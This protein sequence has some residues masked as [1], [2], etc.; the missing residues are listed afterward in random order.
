MLFQKFQSSTLASNFIKHILLNTSLPILQKISDNDLLIKGNLYIYDKFVIEAVE[1]GVFKSV[2]TA[3]LY[4]SDILYPSP[5]LILNVGYKL[6]RYRV[7]DF[8][9]E[10]STYKQQ[11]L[12]TSS[13]Y[14]HNTH[15]WLGSY[16][17][18]LRD[19]KNLNLFPFYNCYCGE[20]I[21]HIKLYR[22]TSRNVSDKD[23]EYIDNTDSNVFCIPVRFGCNYTVAIDSNLPVIMKLCFYN[24][25]SNII[26]HIKL[27]SNVNQVYE[28]LSFHKPIY[29]QIPTAESI[30]E[31]QQESNLT[32]LIQIS[33]NVKTSIAVLEGMYNYNKALKINYSEEDRTDALKNN[34]IVINNS[35]SDVSRISLLEANTGE[36]YAFSFRLIEYLLLNIITEED[37]LDNNISYL[38]ELLTPQLDPQVSFTDKA[39]FWEDLIDETIHKILVNNSD[40]IFLRDQ[41]GQFNCDIEQL[42][43]NGRK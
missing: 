40:N 3:T 43:I 16:L 29:I 5:M 32:L 31:I 28:N 19:F 12:N 23:F 15:K 6:G 14:D 20:S 26:N 41:D 36:S 1:D 25:K 21:N 34:P 7:I 8:Y 9:D 22:P 39:E 11:F 35:Y 17:R 2:D 13:T 27:N 42:L 24:D 10:S 4:P 30:V 38:K 37:P 33:K 18:Y